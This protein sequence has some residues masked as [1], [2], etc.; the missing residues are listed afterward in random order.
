MINNIV[1]RPFYPLIG[2]VLPAHIIEQLG[3]YPNKTA[4]DVTGHVFYFL[5]GLHIGI[6]RD[7]NGYYYNIIVDN[8]LVISTDLE[9]TYF[10]NRIQAM[11]AATIRASVYTTTVINRRQKIKNETS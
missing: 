4:H 9:N 11:Q 10:N 6:S 8:S 3:V 5:K 7:D 2:Y 1:E